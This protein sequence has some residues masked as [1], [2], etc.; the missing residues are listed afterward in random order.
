MGIEPTTV[1]LQSRT[2]VPAPRRPRHIIQCILEKSYNGTSIRN[3]VEVYSDLSRKK[4]V[5]DKM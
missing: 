1:T 2:Y 3:I 4:L 5:K